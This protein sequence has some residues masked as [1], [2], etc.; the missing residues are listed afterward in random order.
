M[1]MYSDIVHLAFW[2]RDILDSFTLCY[3]QLVCYWAVPFGHPEHADLFRVVVHVAN[4]A[5]NSAVSSVRVQTDVHL[6]QQFM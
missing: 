2:H 1:I 4:T 6:A 5:N 3:T